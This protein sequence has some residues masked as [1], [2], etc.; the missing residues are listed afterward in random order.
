MYLMCSKANLWKTA[1]QSWQREV[2]LSNGKRMSPSLHN[3][4][5]KPLAWHFWWYKNERVKTEM[6]AQWHSRTDF[7]SEVAHF[8]ETLSNIINGPTFFSSLS[9]L[10]CLKRHPQTYLTVQFNMFGKSCVNFSEGTAETP[11]R[12]VNQVL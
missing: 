1:K 2:W 11:T 9:L 6:L 4:H 3:S 8:Q 5:M 10:L 7:T 12:G